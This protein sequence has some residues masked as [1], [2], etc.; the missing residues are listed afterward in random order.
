MIWNAHLLTELQKSDPHEGHCHKRVSSTSEGRDL[1]M[2]GVLIH[3][4]GDAL[5]NIG[6]IIAGL[7]I[8]LAKYEGRYYADPATGIG[9]AILITLSALPLGMCRVSR[10]LHT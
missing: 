3:V 7:V 5:N 6:V 1:G 10:L 8:W 9:I 4:V 2:L